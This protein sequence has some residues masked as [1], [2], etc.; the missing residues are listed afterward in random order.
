MTIAMGV[1]GGVLMIGMMLGM[2]FG[3]HGRKGKGH[4]HGGEKPP[5]V[6]T[7]TAPGADPAPAEHVH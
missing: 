1:V 5:A 6:S 3:M 2:M 7:A 4:D